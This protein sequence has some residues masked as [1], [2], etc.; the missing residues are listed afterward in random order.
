LDEHAAAPT[1]G[2]ALRVAFELSS[3]PLL[4]MEP[5]GRIVA[6]NSA[7][8][9][10][11]G[12]TREALVGQSLACVAGGWF[13]SELPGLLEEWA[14]EPASDSP[15]LSVVGQRDGRACRMEFERVSTAGGIPDLLVAA[16]ECD[17][18][19]SHSRAALPLDRDELTGLA[20]RAA[21]LERGR[22]MLR[23]STDPPGNP[24]VCFIDFNNFKAINDRY[25]HAAGDEVLRVTAQ[26]LAGS[27]R[28]EDL[29]ARYGGDELVVVM[30]HVASQADAQRI[31]Q[32][33][34]ALLCEP[35][36][37]AGRS[38]AVSVSVGV[39]FAAGKVSLEELLDQADRAMYQAKARSRSDAQSRPPHSEGSD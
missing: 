4:V 17:A 36:E 14:A 39:A 13:G 28:P 37:H 27:V 21:L 12:S 1:L 8:G 18:A 38:I 22:A 10:W 34:E 11:L 31:S 25:R 5:S 35:V 15:H 26:R 9:V 19:A 24:A 33:L 6:A 29:V 23:A 16:I 32:R 7:A 30:Q 20:T 3:T 2:P